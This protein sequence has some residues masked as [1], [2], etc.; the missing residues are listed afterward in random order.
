MVAGSVARFS[1]CMMQVEHLEFGHIDAEIRTNAFSPFF[2]YYKN[3][4]DH[5]I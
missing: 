2:Y 4:L 5:I 3:I 1:V